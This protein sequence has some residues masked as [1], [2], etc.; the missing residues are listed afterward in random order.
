[1][2]YCQIGIYSLKPE[3]V[4]FSFQSWTK[5]IA[6]RFKFRYNTEAIYDLQPFSLTIILMAK[7]V[8]KIE[9]KGWIMFKYFFIINRGTRRWTSFWV[10]F[11]SLPLCMQIF[12]WIFKQGNKG[13]GQA[14]SSGLFSHFW[15]F[16]A[17]LGS[18]SCLAIF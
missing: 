16:D 11:V 15:I 7:K 6:A 9:N 13:Y 18:P 12:S 3:Q 14:T 5:H 8:A 17:F 4:K 1:M 10:S 2:L